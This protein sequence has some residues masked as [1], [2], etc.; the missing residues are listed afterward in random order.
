MRR[1][2]VVGLCVLAVVQAANIRAEE[3]DSQAV[4]QEDTVSVSREPPQ[5]GLFPRFKGRALVMD[6]NAR[7]IEQNQTVIWNESHKKTTLPGRPVGIK[8]VGSN[9]VVVAQFTPYVRRG[10]KKILVA[11]GQIWMEVPNQGIR[12]HTSMQAIPL[13]FGE[14]IYFFPLG[15]QN[16]EDTACIE[17]ML[18]LYPYE[19]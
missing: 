9:L 18:T 3:P 5:Q 17:V 7:V 15:P 8:L 11:Q 1:L 6:I 12:Y 14:P 16:A 2:Y 10:I 4:Q 13:E 19:E